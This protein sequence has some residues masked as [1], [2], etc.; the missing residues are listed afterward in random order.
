MLWGGVSSTNYALEYGQ[1]AAT[2]WRPYMAPIKIVM[3][4]GILLML[5]QTFAFFFRDL[6]RVR[7][8]EIE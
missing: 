8:R 4:F 6:A 7:G 2:S 3:T 1:R 5:L